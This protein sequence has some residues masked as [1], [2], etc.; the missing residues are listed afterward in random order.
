M[1]MAKVFGLMTVMT[2]PLRAFGELHGRLVHGGRLLRDRH[3][4]ELLDV[5]VQ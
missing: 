3:G 4:H 5:L 2:R 1:Q